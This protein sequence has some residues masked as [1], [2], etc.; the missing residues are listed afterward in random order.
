VNATLAL[1][2][3]DFLDKQNAVSAQTGNVLERRMQ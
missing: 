1:R 2:L 3:V